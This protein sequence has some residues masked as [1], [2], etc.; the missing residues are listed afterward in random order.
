MFFIGV[1]WGASA[2]EFR[3]YRKIRNERTETGN[4]ETKYQKR[5]TKCEWLVKVFNSSV[6]NFVEKTV[7]I[8]ETAHDNEA[9]STLH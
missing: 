4:F 3:A 5:K 9:Y 2:L 7:W 8:F 6:E 1:Q